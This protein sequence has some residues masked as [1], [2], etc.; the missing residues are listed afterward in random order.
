[1]DKDLEDKLIHFGRVC[2]IVADDL[3]QIF[4]HFMD[5]ISPT[6]TIFPLSEQDLKKA[7]HRRKYYRM[8]ERRK[9]KHG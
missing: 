4:T 9:A 8:M 2:G 6:W 7:R 3:R 5:A 1:M